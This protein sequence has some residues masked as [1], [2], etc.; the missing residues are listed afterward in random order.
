MKSMDIILLSFFG[1]ASAFC[2]M[3]SSHKKYY[4]KTVSEQGEKSAIRVFRL[5]KLGGYILGAV[6]LC[7]LALI[8]FA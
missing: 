7:Y 6:F 2:L 3:F 5:I 8:I 4:E 1:F